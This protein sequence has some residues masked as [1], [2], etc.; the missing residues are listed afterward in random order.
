M[1][2]TVFMRQTRISVSPQ[3]CRVMRQQKTLEEMSL[4]Q[5]MATP[6]YTLEFILDRPLNKRAVN[7]GVSV[8]TPCRTPMGMLFK[9]IS[10]S[11]L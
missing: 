6:N 3:R 7:T 4:W 10:R 2:H 9:K 5:S 8:S 1:E 11:D